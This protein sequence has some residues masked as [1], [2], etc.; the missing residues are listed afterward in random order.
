LFGTR[1][2]ISAERNPERWLKQVERDGHGRV[3]AVPLTAAEAT[4]EMLLMGLRLTEGVDL[5]RVVGQGGVR[6]APAAIAE[7]AELGLIEAV[8][9]PVGAWRLCATDKGRFVLNEIVLRLSI[10]TARA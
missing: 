5:D 9:G 3:E 8:P 2:A 6:P 10:S 1:H 7:L 4:D